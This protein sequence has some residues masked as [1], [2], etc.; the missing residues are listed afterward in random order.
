ML[1]NA[2][3]ATVVPVPELHQGVFVEI[4]ATSV[5]DTVS[6]SAAEKGLVAT[7]ARQVS[8][9]RALCFSC[10]AWIEARPVLKRREGRSAERA[11]LS[12][13]LVSHDLAALRRRRHV[14]LNEALGPFP[15]LLGL[16]CSTTS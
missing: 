6:N 11:N 5:L 12:F 9:L 15:V 3:I 13:G 1:L 10:A 14:L 7:S 2:Q 16:A 4:E 8:A